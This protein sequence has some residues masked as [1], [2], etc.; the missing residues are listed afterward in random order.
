MTDTANLE[1][2]E[3]RRRALEAEA[4]QRWNAAHPIGT[5]VRY[6][7]GFREGEG[8]AGTTRT[9]AQLL[10]GHTAV[11]W[12]TGESSCISLTHVEHCPERTVDVRDLGFPMDDRDLIYN[13]LQSREG[14]WGSADAALGDE[15]NW[16][17]AEVTEAWCERAAE[18]LAEHGIVWD[19]EGPEDRVTLPAGMGRTAAERIWQEVTDAFDAWVDGVVE[20]TRSGRDRAPD[21]GLRPDDAPGAR[22][23]DEPT[24]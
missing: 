24:A 2:A 22:W 23:V 7:T 18:L 12:V 11:V 6:W 8:A 13:G 14:T 20:E 17:Y 15:E 4:V 1:P 10:G 16:A 5:P 3:A 19:P 9:E 21:D